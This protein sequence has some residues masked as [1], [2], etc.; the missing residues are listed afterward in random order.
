ME[1]GRRGP[2]GGRGRVLVRGAATLLLACA[3]V[4]AGPVAA[5]AAGPGSVACGVDAGARGPA[6]AAVPGSLVPVDRA[7]GRIS[8]VQVFSDATAP[9]A[10][11]VWHR[12]QDAPD[13]PYGPWRRVSA[14]AVDPGGRS[15]I[16]FENTGGELEVLFT[17]GGSLCRTVHAGGAWSA[18]DR[19]GPAPAPDLEGVRFPSDPVA[20]PRAAHGGTARLE[21]ERTSGLL[22]GDIVEF[23]LAG[24]PPKAFVWVKQCGPS[25]SAA[26]CDDATG[27][28]FRVLP[29]GTHQLSPKKLYAR[30]GTPAGDFDCRTA[31]ATAPCTLTLTDN[32]GSVLAAVPLRFR[33]HGG[34]E[35]PPTLRVKPDG[36]LVDGRTVRATG[37]GYEPRYHSL[38]MQCAA[39]SADTRGCRPRGR[40]PATTDGGRLDE[41]VALS[42]TFTSVDGRTV[43]CRARGACELVV[44]GTRVRGPETVRRSLDFAPGGG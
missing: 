39:G 38:I 43:D 29:D 42:A 10:G 30:L 9:E 13:S 15:P 14:T 41:E 44:F 24:G 28:Q 18:T 5:R 1:S 36:G 35:A 22:D 40:P 7:D 21:V 25:A 19:I 11:F 4:V 2:R 8:Q 12:E 20:R 6:G 33:P 34:P 27:R 17:E 32:D 37:T 23:T 3:G 26:T 31:S 16:A